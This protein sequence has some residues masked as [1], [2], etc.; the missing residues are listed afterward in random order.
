MLTRSARPRSPHT[1][2]RHHRTNNAH[3]GD[4]LG[5]YKKSPRLPPARLAAASTGQGR[6]GLAWQER[7]RSVNRAHNNNACSNACTPPSLPT[8]KWSRGRTNT[9]GSEKKA[10][11]AWGHS[12]G[13]GS[14]GWRDE[15]SGVG[16]KSL[17]S[18]ARHRG[19]SRCCSA[20][21]GALGAA[22][23]VAQS[24]LW[25]C[26][27]THVGTVK[28]TRGWIMP[29]RYHAAFNDAWQRA[30]QPRPPRCLAAGPTP[31]AV[32]PA[33]RRG[34]PPAASADSDMPSPFAVKMKSEKRLR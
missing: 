2:P 17:V 24:S 23:S 32:L 31:R 9:S 12:S 28:A 14:R 8:N 11:A 1:P 21:C 26:S 16:P 5:Q 18:L 27:W 13:Q 4:R 29:W 30:C 15:R 20:S 10:V 19:Q 22:L 6:P 3:R 33:A 34:A 7:K 25:G